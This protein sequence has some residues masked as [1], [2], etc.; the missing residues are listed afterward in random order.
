MVVPSGVGPCRVGSF[1][2]TA[3][4]ELSDAIEAS[5]NHMTLHSGDVLFNE[6]EPGEVFYLVQRGEIE[7]SVH[8]VD[9]RKLSLAVMRD[10]ET[11][12]EIALFGG[13]RTATARA[14]DETALLAI[15]RSDVLAMLR[16]RPELALQFI[17]LLCARLRELSSKLEERAFESVPVRLASRLLYLDGK[18]GHRGRVAVSQ[19]QLAD[20][21]GA[22]REGVA[23]ALAIWRARNWVA[24]SRGTIHF[25][26]RAALERLR[27]ELSE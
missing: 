17:D 16:K 11:F 23:K 6:G 27:R 5:A 22:T 20:F 1:L 15:P 2:A 10:G 26:D 13:N 12:G 19:A 14:L 18:L 3:S 24:L 4:Q 7:I 21:V 9:G 8:A 25:L